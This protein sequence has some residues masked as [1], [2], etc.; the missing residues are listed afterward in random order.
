[1][2][3]L[4]Q[5]RLGSITSGDP[6]TRGLC[7]YPG[8]RSVEKHVWHF[9]P[10]L[11]GLGALFL[12]RGVAKLCCRLRGSDRALSLPALAYKRASSRDSAVRHRSDSDIT[13]DRSAALLEDVQGA[14]STD[15]T[16][17]PHNGVARGDKR[18]ALGRGILRLTLLAFSTV[19]QATVSLLV[20]VDIG[21]KSRLVI[22]GT[23]ECLAS[24]QWVALALLFLVVVPFPVVLFFWSRRVVNREFSSLNRDSAIATLVAPCKH[25]SAQS[26]RPRSDMPCSV[27]TSPDRPKRYW[28]ESWAMMRRLLMVVVYSFVHDYLWR[29]L[30]M[31]LLVVTLISANFAG[32][33][34]RR[35]GVQALETLALFCLFLL[36]ALGARRAA[37]ATAGSSLV[38]TSASVESMVSFVEVVL[39]LMPLAWYIA[40]QIRDWSVRPAWRMYKRHRARTAAS[41]RF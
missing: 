16:S 9:L 41:D 15:G 14:G 3:Q 18:L 1:M 23:V 37:A 20:C 26:I 27:S 13:G 10:P 35:T 34:F 40:S 24:F 6:S 2:L 25:H 31:L 19:S 11:L 21:G 36:T 30:T 28:W 12:T 33:P 39:L 29:Q 17:E 8:M 5:L 4:V 32:R 22:D 7:L 38:D